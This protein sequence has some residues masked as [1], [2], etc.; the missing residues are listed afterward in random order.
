MHT[1]GDSASKAGALHSMEAMSIYGNDDCMWWK[2]VSLCSSSIGDVVEMRV[3][4]WIL[5]KV[6]FGRALLSDETIVSI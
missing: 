1:C 4:H 5:P 3:V 2:S 6:G